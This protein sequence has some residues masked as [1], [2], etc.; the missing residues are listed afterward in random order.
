MTGSGFGEADALTGRLARGLPVGTITFLLTDVEGSSRHWEADPAAAAALSRHEEIIA[1]CVTRHG[2]ARPVE[3]GEGDSSLLAFARASD[4]A[5][6]A[7][8]IQRAP[9]FYAPKTTS[10]SKSTCCGSATVGSKTSSS[11]PTFA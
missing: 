4:A 7:I 3:Q 6:C 5:T 8:D 1:D 10:A 2:G 9:R 11:T